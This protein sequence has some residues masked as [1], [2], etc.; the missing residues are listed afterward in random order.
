VDKI[1]A[2]EVEPGP[3]GDSDGQPIKD[4]VIEKAVLSAQ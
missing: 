1:G 2:V 4:V 3:F